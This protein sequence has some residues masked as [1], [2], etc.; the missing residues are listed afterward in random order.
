MMQP[1]SP[2]LPERMCRQTFDGLMQA[3]TTYTKG[4]QR[5]GAYILLLSRIV[6]AQTVLTL[7]NEAA[8][9]RGEPT[10]LIDYLQHQRDDAQSALVA[11]LTEEALR[12]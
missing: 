2:S 1:P 5:D 11:I 7:L 12:A 9:C 10:E 6:D 4:D 3:I 8:V